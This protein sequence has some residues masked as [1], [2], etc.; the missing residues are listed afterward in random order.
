MESMCLLLSL[1]N[2]HKMKRKIKVCLSDSVLRKGS[3]TSGK[4]FQNIPRRR[5]VLEE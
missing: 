5:Y 4:V 3:L 2:P 1:L